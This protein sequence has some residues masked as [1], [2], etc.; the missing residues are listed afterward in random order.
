MTRHSW[1][2]AANPLD[3][4]RDE[5][6]RHQSNCRDLDPETFFPIGTSGPALLQTERAK[7]ICRRCDV[8]DDCLNFALETGQDAGVWGGMSEEERR[9]VKRRGGLRVL[10]AA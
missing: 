4:V 6:W 2:N 9:A 3:T 10:R 1:N 7:A 8:I 5:D